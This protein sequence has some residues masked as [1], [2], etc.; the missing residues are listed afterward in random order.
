M[1]ISG[2]DTGDL[3]QLLDD[4]Y[5]VE[6]TL[7]RR[8]LDVRRCDDFTQVIAS[9]DEFY[10]HIYR[11]RPDLEVDCG[12]LGDLTKRPVTEEMVEWATRRKR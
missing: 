3:K 1:N 4:F 8:G 9:S 5:S 11:R 10:A 6:N 12:G 2:V 7:R